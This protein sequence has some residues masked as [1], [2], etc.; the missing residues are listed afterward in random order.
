MHLIA[1]VLLSASAQASPLQGPA[2]RLWPGDAPLAVGQEEKDV[3]TIHVYAAKGEGARPAVVVC[4]G[5]GYGMLAKGHEGHDI[6]VWLNARGASAFVLTYRHAP[7]YRHPVPMLDVQRAIRTVRARAAEWRVDPARIGVWGF[8]AGGHLASTAATKFDD[9]RP[10]AEDPVERASCRPDFAILSYPVIAFGEP[11]THRGSQKNLLGDKWED[12]ELVR[13]LSSEKQVTERTP[14]CFLFH[15]TTD[16]PVPPENSLVFYQALRKAK[17]PA[18]LHVYEQG[19]HG[20]GLGNDRHPELK[21]W[22]DRLAGW[23]RVRG[24]FRD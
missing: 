21:S 24:I 3:P 20:V 9:G 12:P 10:D 15:T 2:Q 7:R 19:P 22:P 17:V 8:S 11:Y 6:A 5:G 4:P 13:L 23:L 16:A 18:E 14:P 1:A